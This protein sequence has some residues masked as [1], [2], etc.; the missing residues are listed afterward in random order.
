MRTPYFLAVFGV[1]I[2]SPLAMAAQGVDDGRPNEHFCPITL[3]VM[4]DPVVAADGQ[5]Y[6]RAAITRWFATS[7]K[8]P[9]GADLEHTNLIA[10]LCNSSAPQPQ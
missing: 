5:S 10:N 1:L 9:L 3:S 4:V 6:E 2:S 8:N 7:R